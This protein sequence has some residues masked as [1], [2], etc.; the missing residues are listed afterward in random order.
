MNITITELELR[1]MEQALNDIHEWNE[2]LMTWEA[3]KENHDFVKNRLNIFT[4]KFGF[5]PL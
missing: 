5:A 4:Q 1:Q 2:E 3:S